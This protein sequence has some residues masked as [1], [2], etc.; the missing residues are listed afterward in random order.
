MYGDSTNCFLGYTIDDASLS[1][2]FGKF[3]F[4]PC[5]VSANC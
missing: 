3:S 1:F 2:L 4:F 5:F